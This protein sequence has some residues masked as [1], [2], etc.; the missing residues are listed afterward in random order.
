M[1]LWPSAIPRAFDFL[2]FFQNQV[3]FSVYKM[4]R[5]RR[6]SNKRGN[7]RNQGSRNKSNRGS[8]N[9][10]K[11]GFNKGGDS[12]KDDSS[13]SKRQ[14]L[15]LEKEKQ[16]VVEEESSSSESEEEV[17]P[18]IQLLSMF[19]SSSK[20]Q[21]VLTSDEEEQSEEEIEEEQFKEDDTESEGESGSVSD[22]DDE[23]TEEEEVENSLEEEAEEEESDCEEEQSKLEQEDSEESEEELLEDEPLSSTDPFSLHYERELSE[24]LLEILTSA[25]PYE[26][27]ELKWKVLGR[28]VVHLP[29]K[30]ESKM[31]KPKPILEDSVEKFVIPGTLPVLKTGIPMKDYGIKLQLC[32]NLDRRPLS[33]N[34]D[35][36]TAEELLSPLQHELFTLA[37]DYRDVYYPEM[38][39]SNNDEIRTVYCL[40]SLNHILK[41]RDRVLHHNAK[42]KKASESGAM[43]GEIEY[44]DQGLVRPRVLIIAPLRNSAVK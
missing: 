22:I 11:R 26:T 10:H 38:N 18:Y 27:Q 7:Y 24:N 9:K 37:N 23:E 4:G 6:G 13:E 28:M 19:K 34:N 20:A 1:Q 25:K 21:Q 32:T 5:G 12:N 42:L 14:K 3:A 17:K 15:E 16:P 8:G 35:T 33:D 2:I 44:R 43:T 36:Q 29:R 30:I 40:H 39:H 41:S 31:E